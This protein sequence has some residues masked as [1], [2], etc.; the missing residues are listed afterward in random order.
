MHQVV[1]M[2]ITEEVTWKVL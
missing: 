1:K 2:Q